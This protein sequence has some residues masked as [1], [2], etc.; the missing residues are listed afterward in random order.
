MR[1]A[2]NN[3]HSGK[4]SM[5]SKWKLHTLAKMKQY[6]EMTAKKSTWNKKTSIRTVSK[7]RKRAKKKIN[8]YWLFN[9]FSARHVWSMHQGKSNLSS[10]S[11]VSLISNLS[12]MTVLVLF[13]NESSFS[14]FCCGV[15]FPGLFFACVMY[16]LRGIRGRPLTSLSGIS[17]P[18]NFSIRPTKSTG[19]WDRRSQKKLPPAEN[20]QN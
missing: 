16:F 15:N 9:A 11:V 10:I 18:A 20:F 3:R 12:W 5:S 17:F 7:W 4:V 6:V 14:C 13:Y 8:N 19:P 1:Y 2:C